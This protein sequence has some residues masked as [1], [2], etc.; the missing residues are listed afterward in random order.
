MTTQQ[1]TRLFIK[2]QSLHIQYKERADA[3]RQPV[4]RGVKVYSDD[5]ARMA[6][7]KANYYEGMITR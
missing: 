3:Y 2:Y 1:A 5:V 4:G 6:L 7:N